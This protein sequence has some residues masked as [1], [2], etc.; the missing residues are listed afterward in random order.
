[1]TKEE[2][3]TL[4]E[5]VYR[6]MYGVCPHDTKKLAATCPT[7]YAEKAVDAMEKREVVTWDLHSTS[8]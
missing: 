7:C 5:N 2:L 6:M 8:R 3:I 4:L 1:M